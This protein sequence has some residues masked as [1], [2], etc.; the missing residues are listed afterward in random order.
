MCEDSLTG[1]DYAVLT[2]LHAPKLQRAIVHVVVSHNL[3]PAICRVFETL[4]LAEAW[5]DSYDERAR[6]YL[7]VVSCPVRSSIE[8]RG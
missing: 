8:E 2:P 4:A 3:F 5:R 1:L 7:Q 6:R